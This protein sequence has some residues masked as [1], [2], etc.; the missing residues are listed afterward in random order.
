MGNVAEKIQQNKTLAV[1]R[2]FTEHNA[3]PVII[4]ALA[5]ICYFLALPL[6][7][8]AVFATLFSFTF[9]FSKDTRSALAPV[10]LVVFT[11]CYKHEPN[12]YK[13]VSA[14]V[15][16]GIFGP[17]F[18]AS[19]LFHFIVYPVP[20]QKHR[21]L[22]G[23]VLFS[24][25]MFIGG[26][27][28]EYYRAFNFVN[29]LSVSAVM[30]CCYGLFSYTEC[31][32][33]D[34]MLYL[35]R[36]CAVAIC[37]IATELLHCYVKNYHFGT[38]LDAIWKDKIVL[39]WGMS[40]FIGEML[41]MLMP[42]VFYLIYKE[43]HGYL[44]YLVAVIGLVAI[45]FTLSRNATLFGGGAFCI[46]LL[47][48]AILKRNWLNW[49]ILV[50][51]VVCGVVGVCVLNYYGN[52]FTELGLTDN[53]RFDLWGEYMKLFKE[54]PI[55][56]VGVTAYRDTHPGMQLNAHNTVIHMLSGSGIVGLICY[57]IHRAQTLWI[58]L[59]KPRAD[60]LFIGACIVV[61][62]G[63]SLLSPI[64]FRLYFLVYYTVFLTMIEKSL[65]S[66]LPTE[67]KPQGEETE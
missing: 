18:L 32:R 38:G 20:K 33:K 14:F 17:I 10:L 40:N 37:V 27:G 24:I 45:Y 31:N 39:G 47:L 3:Y 30:L 53:G 6:L 9:F 25:G 21:L 52:T 57:L 26:V 50:G 43:K 66:E 35:A 62:V 61:G 23:F 2:A 15:V 49:S 55:L 8:V 58:L 44:Y 28:C 54:S 13:T 16:Y 67:T 12:A 46:G 41:A 19:I 22:I 11:L 7:A 4:G 34:N 5:L 48:N 59:K 36:I 42:A 64:F 63:V 29:A 65:E 51:I 56:G 1:L 60:R